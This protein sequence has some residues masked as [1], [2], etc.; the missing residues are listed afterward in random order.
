MI[1]NI[2]PPLKAIKKEMVFVS[3]DLGVSELK[4]FFLVELP[5]VSKQIYST[6]GFCFLISFGEFSA[7]SF[8]VRPQTITLP[9]VLYQNLSKTN[10][11][12]F[13][14]SLALSVII[15]FMVGFVICL[16]ERKNVGD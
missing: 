4:T 11:F 5:M 1:R 15:L 6:L 7:T 8:L 13:G 2:L 16:V 9:F 10:P 12:A 3:Y 14:Q